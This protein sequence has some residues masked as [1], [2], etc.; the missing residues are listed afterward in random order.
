M[1]RICEYRD[2][3]LD[4]L[5]VGKGQVRTV[6]ADADLDAL[7]TSIRVQGQLQPIIVCA[8]A[9]QPGKWEI[10]AGQRRFLA[11]KFLAREGEVDASTIAA[12]VL[13]EQVQPEEAKAISIT[14]NLIRRKLT[15][16]EL[17]DGVTFLYNKY[18]TIQAVVEATGLSWH[19][20][21]AYV[22]YPRLIPELK[23]MVDK[24]M[25]VNVALKAQ[26][27]ASEGHGPV[28]SEA[29][30]TLAK[31]M[32]TMSGVQRDKVRQEVKGDPSQPIEEVIERARSSG[33]VTQ[34][35][36]TLTQAA[37]SALRAFAKE[38][39]SNQDEAAAT[40][41]MEGLMGRGLLEDS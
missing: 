7:A 16:K 10:L 18:G 38:E 4:D 19:H 31:E 33:K 2:I 27:A 36:V 20:V 1:A 24:G 11:H 35:A 6:A 28:N 37:H 14:E 25:N 39:E 30:V 40:L 3:S 26:D 32:S 23:E 41:I 9:Q 5:V 8:S 13:D 29:A 22:K 17:I 21:S 15:G 34:V 12:A